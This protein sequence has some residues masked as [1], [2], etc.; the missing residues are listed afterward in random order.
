MNT[1]TATI[2]IS[3]KLLEQIEKY[4]EKKHCDKSDL[5]EKVMKDYLSN[6]EVQTKKQR[7]EPEK[8]KKLLRKLALEQREEILEN[9]DYQV[10]LW[11]EDNF[12]D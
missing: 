3:V 7:N 10:D 11:N 4:A 6:E 9:L 8:E 5:I 12:T 1:E 2:P